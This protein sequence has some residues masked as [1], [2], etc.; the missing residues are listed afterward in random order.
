MFVF[1]AVMAVVAAI[2]AA[3]PVFE[4]RDLGYT[5][6]PWKSLVPRR[7]TLAET[8]T[9][10]TLAAPVVAFLFFMSYRHRKLLRELRG[11]DS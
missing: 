5:D 8:A 6:F 4:L 10:F 2:C 7:P 1:T 9:R 11:R 3:I